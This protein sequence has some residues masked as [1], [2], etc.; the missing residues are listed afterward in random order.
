MDKQ[1]QLKVGDQ[2]PEFSLPNQDGKEV[3]LADFQGRWVILYF[4]P[5]DN[6]PGCTREAIDFTRH[7]PE[8]E[9]LG[10]VVLGVSPDSTKSHCNFQQ[11]HSLKVTLLSDPTHQ[12]LSAYGAWKPKKLYGREFL[13]VVRSTFLIDPQ[14]KIAHI[15]MPVNVNGHVEDVLHTLQHLQTTF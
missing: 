10:A 1:K 12:V 13:G 15:W 7:L 9:N 6:T 8:L 14:Q 2:A 5:K 11:K 4:Y 3:R